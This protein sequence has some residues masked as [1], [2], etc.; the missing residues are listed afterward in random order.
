MHIQS[1]ALVVFG[2]T[3]ALAG[4]K[5]EPPVSKP[6]GVEFFEKKIRPVLVKHC[7]ECHSGDAKKLRGELLLDSREG[8]LKGGATGPVVVPGDPAKSLLIKAVRHDGRNAQDAEGEAL[9]QEIA[10]LEA[11]VKM[12]APDP[13]T[14]RDEGEAARR[15][16]GEGVLVVQAGRATTQCRLVAMQS[17]KS[18]MKSTRSSSRSSKTKGLTPAPPA[19][20]RTLIRRATFDLTGLPPTP[21]EIDA[22][23]EDESPDAFAKVVDRLL[24]SPHTASAGAG[25]GSTW[26]ATPTPRAT[27][28]TTPSRRCTGTATG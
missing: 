25:T 2:I 24:A 8:V 22:F 3:S 10:D 14:R 19:D 11:W 7:Y 15:R 12:G 23:L 26:S 28:P 13:R 21:E 5:E 1:I 20:K 4:V 18:G 16:E 17:T 6:E 27:T 9:G